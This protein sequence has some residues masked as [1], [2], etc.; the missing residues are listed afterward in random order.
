MRCERIGDLLLKFSRKQRVLQ[1]EYASAGETPIVDQSSGTLVVGYT[2]NPEARHEAPLPITVFGDHTR[3][4][5]Y[6]DFPFVSGADGTQLL[7]PNT[8][9][10]DPTYFFYAVRNVDLSNYFYARHL[11]FLKEQQIT[12]PALK[13]QHRIAE[14]LRTYDDLIENNRRRVLAA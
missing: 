9:D 7:Y 4:V 1:S 3:V 14:T 8:P 13:T 5:K 6:V 10:L 11:K 2:D 12:I